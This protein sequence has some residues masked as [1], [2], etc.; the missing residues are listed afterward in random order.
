MK[1]TG[2]DS[3]ESWK[4]AV[5][6]GFIQIPVLIS[7]KTTGV[8]FVGFLN[9]WQIL[10]KEA[11][12]PLTLFIAS[13]QIFAPIF[14]LL[15]KRFSASSLLIFSGALITISQ[16]LTYFAG[17]VFHFSISFVF[18]GFAISGVYMYSTLIFMQHFRTKR[19][20]ATGL[21]STI[22]SGTTTFAP[23]ILQKLINELGI[24][25]T[26]PL[27]SVAS[28]TSLILS[29]FLKSPQWFLDEMEEREKVRSATQV[30]EQEL[31]DPRDTSETST[32]ENSSHYM[33]SGKFIM[34]VFCIIVIYNANN[35]FL[36]IVFDHARDQGIE[37]TS[38]LLV[39]PFCAV[40]DLMMRI[41]SGILIDGKLISWQVLFAAS[42]LVEATSLIFWVTSSTLPSL[43]VLSVLVG[44]CN[45]ALVSLIPVLLVNDFGIS[46]FTESLGASLMAC[47]IVTCFRPLLDGYFRDVRGSYDGM[48]LVLLALCVPCGIYW[49]SRSVYHIRML[50]SEA[51]QKRANV[52]VES[53]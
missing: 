26:M 47:G 41:M 32:M 43:L 17:S 19:T 40:G 34:D 16:C 30:E 29:L 13:S 31:V 22:S 14:P 35:T 49:L 25:M 7:L 38:A 11:S 15:Q 28:L 50:P 18:Q 33:L 10:R 23:N 27:L 5:L 12:W 6:A 39:L 44:G 2:P 9:K 3:C 53:T 45:G 8:V 46:R 4:N 21:A 20:A 36:M 52:D 48:F 42:F 37:E 24:R 1:A 51:L